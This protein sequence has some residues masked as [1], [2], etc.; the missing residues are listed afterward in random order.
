LC[1]SVSFSLLPGV[2]PHGASLSLNW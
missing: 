2:V 1:I